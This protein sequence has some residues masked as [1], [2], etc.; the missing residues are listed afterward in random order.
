[1]FFCSKAFFVFFFTL[2]FRAFKHQLTDKII[3]RKVEYNRLDLN[4]N[5]TLIL[6]YLNPINPALELLHERFQLFGVTLCKTM[7]SL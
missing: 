5:F 6:C 7:T 4:Y 1:M 3:L 2:H